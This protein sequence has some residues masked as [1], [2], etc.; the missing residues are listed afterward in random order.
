MNSVFTGNSVDGSGGG[1]IYNNATGGQSSPVITNSIFADNSVNGSGGAIYNDGSSLQIRNAVFR[2]NTASSVGGAIFSTPG[3]SLQIVGATFTG[4][5]A[6]RGGALY[7]Q[8]ISV[9][10]A[11]TIL[12]GNTASSNGNE[13]FNEALTLTL[14]HTLIE[15]G[16]AGI[17]GFGSSI[18]DE[19]GN[20][21]T[22]PL[23]ADADRPAGG[24]GILGTADDGLRLRQGSPALNAGNNT[25]IPA[26][27]DTDILGEAR[28]QDGTVSLGAYERVFIAEARLQ[29]VARPAA[30][31]GTI[32]LINL[33]NVG[34]NDAEVDLGLPADVSA[35]DAIG[36]GSVSSSTWT[37]NV[38]AGETATVQI[39]SERGA[40]ADPGLLELTA[41]LGTD[42]YTIDGGGADATDPDDATSNWVLLEAPYGSGTALAFDGTDDGATAEAHPDLSGNAPWTIAFWAKVDGSASGADRQG[43]YLWKGPASQSENRLL[44]IG[45]TD[46]AVEVAHWAN[47]NTYG[48]DVAFDTWQHVAVTYDGNGTQQVYLDGVLQDERTDIG[49]LNINE[50]AW[51]VAQ[52]PDGSDRLQVE[53]DELRMWTEARTEADI[54]EAMH[55]TIPSDTPELVASYRF[56]AAQADQRFDADHDGTTAYDLTGGRDATFEGDPQWT[57]SGA[58]LGQESVIVA[59]ETEA[60]IGADG[61]ALT[62]TVT[63]TT[64]R[65]TLYR[66]GDATA[67]VFDGDAL[68]QG[69][70]QRTNLVWGA[71]PGNTATADLTLSYGDV[72]VPNPSAVGLAERPGPAQTWT[73]RAEEPASETFTLDGQTDSQEV[74][75]YDNGPSILYVDAAASGTGTGASWSD[76]F[77]DL[78]DAL[79]AALSSDVIVIAAGTYTPSRELNA[80][81]ARTATF[82]VTG[83]QD[84]L[85]IYGGWSGSETF[86]DVSEVDAALDSRDL[87]ANETIL[88][89]NINGDESDDS[90]NAYHVL[91]FNGGNG[92]GASSPENITPGT[93]LDGLTITGGNANGGFSN[94]TN[95]GGGLYCDGDSSGNACSPSLT[96]LTFTGNSADFGGAIYNSSINGGTSSPQVTNAIFTGNSANFGGAIYNGGFNNGTSSPQITSATFTGNSASSRG[97]ALYNNGSFNGTSS[98]QITS[99]TFTGNSASSGGALYFRGDGGTIAAQIINSVFASNGADHIGFEDGNAGGQ[100]RFVSSTFTGAT[101]F[102]FDVRFY[103][104]GQTPLEVVGSVLWDN[105]PGGIAGTSASVTDPD[106]A[107][108]VTFSIVEEARYAAGSGDANA[109][110]G[111]IN[112]DPL[113]VDASTPAGLDGVFGT[114]DDGLRLAGGSPAIARGTFAPFE[115]GG[116]AEDVTTD[117]AGKDRIFGARPDLGAFTFD[118]IATTSSDIADA[119]GL[120][121]YLAPTGFDGL[122]LLRDNTAANGGL[123]LT[124]T[125]E[126]PDDPSGE[127]PGNV[128]PFTWTVT[129]SLG[130]APRYDLLLST[131]DLGGI[132]DFSA[133]ML[134]KSDDGG[135]TWDAVDTFSGASLVL[136]EDRALVAVQDL[137]GFSQ[138][139]IGS[140]DPTNPL[141]VEL[142]GFEAQRSGTESVTV[143][144]QTLSETGNAGFEVQ[145]AAASVETSHWGV[146]TTGESWQTIAHL[147]GAGTTDTPQSYRFEDTQLPYAADSLSYRLRQIDTGGT[148]A[149]SEAITIARLVQAAELLP[150]YPNPARGSA[151][152]RF[153]VPERQDVRID[154]YDMLGRRIRTVVDTNAEGRAEAQLDV[155]GL[156]SGTYFLRMHTDAG[157]VDT[158]R[159]TVVR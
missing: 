92:I 52:R 18:N 74:A 127:L 131:E 111:N 135:Q 109:G 12:W 14:A 93:V 47:D 153:A 57:A 81:E 126:A 16:I 118:D 159:V 50:E 29:L 69:E 115:S 44:A 70:T 61:Q 49:T 139:A 67:D 136:D 134:Y 94:S 45:V 151:T 28:I 138:F 15:E 1:A 11:N 40:S 125:G 25:A 146:S 22:D 152:V 105:G 6:D 38:P 150:T 156:A 88:S 73:A 116:I 102:A 17:V 121:G 58:P 90:G 147:D 76:A 157:P 60:T 107:V 96:G 128:A 4:N 112:Q 33:G 56:D 108:A 9:E 140:T 72:T 42:S 51:S 65:F 95:A 75:L 89:G 78:E 97:G 34:V 129:S 59:P 62:A 143:Q 37:V 23:F 98:P 31:T 21:D 119:A 100:P 24:D 84:G 43:W 124:R 36:D 2:G 30:E 71:V 144:W 80:G 141:P 27:I 48:A 39:A 79:S 85:R 41:T 77:T 5:S 68:P 20:L 99:A 148:E 145:R 13:I 103:D 8:M 63:S 104:S 122:V 158:Q 91:V 53:L 86:T 132:S 101:D 54:Q 87:G 66:Y 142:A 32:Q 120:L 82:E 19:G 10:I 114:P 113:F 149:F 106:A 130:T 7:S 64:G 26:G 83:T 155:S 55:Q 3:P 123:T 35:P 110:L 137:V 133:L 154:L 117:L 46:G